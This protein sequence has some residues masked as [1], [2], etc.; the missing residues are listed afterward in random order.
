MVA[1]V[2]AVRDGVSDIAFTAARA[3]YPAGYTRRYHRPGKR[4]CYTRAKDPRY[5]VLGMHER[6]IMFSTA[7]AVYPAGFARSFHLPEKCVRDAR[8]KGAR[9][10]VSGIHECSILLS[11]ARGISTRHAR[12]QATRGRVS[13]WYAWSYGHRSGTFAGRCSRIGSPTGLS[14]EAALRSVCLGRPRSR[15][16]VLATRT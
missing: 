14:P 11:T 7:G 16:Y 9:D 15:K 1:R 8:A 3:R 10:S 5:G 6:S 13:G 4:I 12:V 2:S